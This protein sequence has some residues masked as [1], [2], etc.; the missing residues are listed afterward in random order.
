MSDFLFSIFPNERYIDMTLFQYGW[1]RCSPSHSYGPASRNHYLFHFIISGKGV[2]NTKDSQNQPHEYQLK[3]NQGF[4]IFPGQVTT[5]IADD[6]EPW[7]YAWVEFDGVRAREFIETAGLTY[8]SP[9]YRCRRKELAPPIKEEIM[10]LVQNNKATSLYQMGHLYLF[11]NQLIQSSASS[12]EMTEGKLKDFYIR[13][14]IS[15]IE[16]NY[17]NPITIEDIAEFC[18]LNRSYLGKIFRSSLNQTLQQFLIYYRMNRAAELLKFSDMSV[19]EVA[20]SVGYPNQLHF[21]RAFKKTYD[22]SPS[23]WRKENKLMA[24]VGEK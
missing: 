10:A 2:L 23:V 11:L 13:E 24:L 21:S 9:I 8:N 4:M 6:E 20:G 5:Y 1:E 18:N 17:K 15:F 22:K 7:E 19:N 16:Q 14:A 12:K 3:K